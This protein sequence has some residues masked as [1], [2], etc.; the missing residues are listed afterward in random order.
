MRHVKIILLTLGVLLY[1]VGAGNCAGL[2]DLTNWGGPY[3]LSLIQEKVNGKVT[4]REISGNPITGIIFKDLELTGP[5][6]KTY[7]AADRLEV[8]LSLSSIT[9]F[10]LDLGTLALVKPRIFLAREKS[11]QWN[12]G[13]LAKEAAK[14]AQ[15]PGLVDKIIAY[16]L[17]EIDLSNLVVQQ[18]EV[19]ITDGGVTRCYTDLD[20]KSSLTLFNWGQPQQRASLNLRSLGLTTPQGRAELETRLAY[21]DGRAKIESLNL[22][23]AGQTVVS[24]T[25]EVC[26]PLAGLTC[27]MTGKIGPLAGDKIHGFW[28][29][30]PALWDLSGAI[31]LSSTPEGGKIEVRGKIGQADYAVVGNLNAKVKPAVFDLD[32]D[33]KGLSTAQLKEIKD[34]EAQQIQGLSPVNAHLHLEG[35]GLPWNPES[36][37]A[38]LKLE[39]F[40]YRDLKVDKVELDLSGNARR[41]ALQA[42]VAGNFGAVDL[43]ASGH[44]LPLGDTE[45][46]LSGDLAVQ[47]ANFQPAKVGLTKLGNSSLNS[48]FTGKFRVP[49]SLSLSQAHLAGDL[50]ATGRLADRPLQGLSAGFTLEGRKLT[51]SRANLQTAGLTASLSGTLTESGV[52]VTFDAAVSG[53]RA[54]PLPPGSAFAS[55]TAQGAVRGPW[56]SPQVNLAAQVQKLSL[57]NVTLESANLNGALAGWP[58][59]SG[60]LKL[61]GSQ[62]GTPAGS[63][64][65]LNLTANGTGG[66]WQ[67]QAVATSPKEPKFEVAGTADLAARPLVFRIARLSW[68]GQGLMVKNQTPF[69]VLLLP[70]WEITPATFQIDGG[71]VTIAGLARDQELSGRLEVRDLNAGLLAPLGLAASGKLNGR[72]I[73][74]GT[75]RN[76]I[77]DGQMALTAGK[78]KDFPIRALSTTLAYRDDQA[79]ISGN[80]EGPQQS[81][82]VWK[83]SV[84]VRLSLL[85]FKFTLAQDG[86]D[87]KVQSER[88]NLSLLTAVTKE[89]QTADGA[90]DMSVEARGNPRQPRVSGYVRWSPGS[91]QLRQAGTPYLL[92]P[93]EIRLQ[94]DKILIPGLILQSDGTLRLSGEIVLTGLPRVQTRVEAEN[95]RLLNRGGN[96]L[97]T[98]GAIDLRGPFAA[99]VAKGHLMVPKA[100]FRPTFFRSGKDPD[101]ILLPL[102]PTP[103]GG[104]A[105]PDLYRTM[106]INVSIEAPGNVILKDPMGQMELTAHLKALKKPDQK[107][108]LGGD[109]RAL[110]GTLNIEEKPFKVERGTLTLPGVPGKPILVDLKANYEMDDITLI[111]AVSNT[112][113]NPKISLESLPPLPPADVLS[114]LVF[115]APVATLT[116]DQYLAL[117]AQHLG[118]LGG[119]ST[120]KISEILGSTIPFLG[121]IRVKSGMMSGRPAVGVEKEVTKNVSIFAG[122]NLNEERGTYEQQVGVQYKFNKHLSIES[123]YGTRNSGADVYF[124]YD[125]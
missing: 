15:P 63:F 115:G 37:A 121:G 49:P 74:A 59:Q 75:P 56:K 21:G 9:A 39:P 80:L 92:V 36:L 7:L 38:H 1:L 105:A 3:L 70:G 85:P 69:Q 2:S 106:T 25:G 86:L 32:L 19:L 68:H 88:L 48:C 11:G 95:F 61:V 83:G 94:G 54:L 13:N 67:F 55:L 18:G 51:I 91:L 101:V 44:L 12:L 72:L 10:H 23:L 122:R 17:R 117:G 78:V 40:Q 8:R 28:S 98:N 97:W 100:Q 124:N 107:L 71:T 114:Y 108:A 62:L 45:K 42:S 125:F 96:E 111:L 120:G 20:L 53:S 30:W 5:D 73:L 65:R 24:L 66:Q 84:P 52:D 34:L 79:R 103:K 31:S 41:Q 112:L 22:K 16:F 35:K 27:S 110:H 93:G 64:T 43:K 104:A 46:G 89:V 87:L 60:S 116:K 119:I 77:I 26:R 14:P 123:Q 99:L 29:R 81:R 50:A 4:A 118:V 58:P 33:L 102:K 47:T 57:N 6:G 76:P 113:A 82:L 90:L 109:I